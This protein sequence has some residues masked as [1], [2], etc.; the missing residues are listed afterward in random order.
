MLPN[1]MKSVI[2]SPFKKTDSNEAKFKNSQDSKKPC[3][4]KITKSM[5]HDLLSTMSD[6][7]NSKSIDNKNE[8]S[9]EESEATLL[10]N[11]ATCK[12]VSPAD[13]RKLSLAPE[14]KK[15]PNKNKSEKKLLTNKTKI[16]QEE[17]NK[18]ELVINGKVHRSV[19]KAV[20]YFLSKYDRTHTQSLV[21]RGANGGVAGEDAG[22]I[23][24]ALDRKFVFV[25]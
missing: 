15:P 22:V 4:K 9:D 18:D 13:I 17:S 5:L 1:E 2:L 14:K 7:D 10:V 24:K 25:A 16:S 11:A 20:T 6:D 8:S 23:Y 19:N 12:N 21:D 3:S